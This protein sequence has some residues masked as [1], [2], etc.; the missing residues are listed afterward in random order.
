M[1]LCKISQ[2]LFIVEFVDLVVVGFKFYAISSPW[3]YNNKM[4]I[5]S[6]DRNFD[7]PDRTFHNMATSWRLSSYD[8]STDVKELIPEFFFLPEFFTNMEGQ[9]EMFKI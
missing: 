4:I 8:S 7:I 1:H 3:S 6:P 2:W 5:V 9:S